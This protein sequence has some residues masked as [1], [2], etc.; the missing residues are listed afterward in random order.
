MVV[1]GLKLALTALFVYVLNCGINMISV[2]T[3]I[4]QTFL[5]AAACKNLNQKD[6]AFGFSLA[7]ISL[8]PEVTR[9]MIALSIPVIVEKVAFSFGKVIVN[10]M[11]TIYTP[12][13]R[14]CTWNFQTTSAA[15]PPCL[16]MDSRKG[17]IAIISQNLGA[18]EPKRALKAFQCVLVIDAAIGVFFMTLSLVFIRQISWLFA[19]SDKKFLQMIASIYRYEALGA[20]PLGINA[21]VL[22]LLYG[23][24]KRGRAPGH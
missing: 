16:K 4:S 20:V 18:G 2:A 10:S 9:P 11:S 24:G 5:L 13:D 12:P 14:R 6:N 3:I 23:F 22:S 15:S 7:A 19:G 1:I 8:K 21:A 17:A